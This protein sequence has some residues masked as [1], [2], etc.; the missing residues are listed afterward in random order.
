MRFVKSARLAVVALGL[1][2]LGILSVA[3]ASANP[4]DQTGSVRITR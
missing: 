2:A 3:P 4:A 1:V